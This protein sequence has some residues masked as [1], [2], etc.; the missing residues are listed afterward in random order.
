MQTIRKSQDRGHVSL[1]WLDSR[2]SFSFGGYHDDRHMGFYDLRVINQDIIAPAGGFPTHSHKNME[3]I[4]YVL[5]GELAHKDSL[6]TVATIRAGEV[7]RMTAGR[8]I[9]HSEFNASNT[10]PVELLQI[11]ILP[12]QTDITPGYEQKDIGTSNHDGPLQTIVTKGGGNGVLNIHQDMTLLRGQLRAG[13]A[14][15]YTLLN[16][17]AAWIQMVAG[18]LTMNDEALLPGDATALTNQETLTFIAE[19]NAE[20]LLFDLKS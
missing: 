17:R 1:D 13:E 2:H 18:R 9:S 4:T 8:G 19:E 16:N 3:I 14:V 6:G 11:W 7:Q 10:L 15:C 5:R 20:F 12:E